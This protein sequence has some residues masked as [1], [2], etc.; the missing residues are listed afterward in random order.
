MDGDL[1][2]N[3]SKCCRDH[4]LHRKWD[5]NLALPKEPSLFPLCWIPTDVQRM[6]LLVLLRISSLSKNCRKSLPYHGIMS[7]ASSVCQNQPGPSFPEM[8]SELQQILSSVCSGWLKTSFTDFGGK[9]ALGIKFKQEHAIVVE[10]LIQYNFVFVSH[11][12]EFLWECVYYKMLWQGRAPSR[13]SLVQM[14]LLLT[15]MWSWRLLLIV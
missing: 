3:S 14:H 15:S 12:P 8:R 6:V 11:R 5:L 1:P 4:E 10:I 9:P 13:G 7:S 2:L